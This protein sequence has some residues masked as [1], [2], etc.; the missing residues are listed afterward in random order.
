MISLKS[1]YLEKYQLFSVKISGFAQ[2]DMGFT[3]E[4]TT[5]YLLTAEDRMIFPDKIL[6]TIKNH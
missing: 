6:I 4:V 1:Q 2:N 5:L 3:L